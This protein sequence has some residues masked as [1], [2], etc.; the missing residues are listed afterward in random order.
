M[1]GTLRVKFQHDRFIE[2][3]IYKNRKKQKKVSLKSVDLK[4]Q[5]KIGT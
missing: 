2:M 3:T 5:N 4:Q 1:H